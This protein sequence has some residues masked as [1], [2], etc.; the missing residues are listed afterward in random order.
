[1]SRK[2]TGEAGHAGTAMP[3]VDIVSVCLN[4]LAGLQATFESVRSQ[5]LPPQRWI[6][7][8]GGSTDGTQRWLESL[9]WPSLTWT[10]RADGGIYHGMNSGLV[11]AKS[12]YVLFLNS[13]DALADASVL[14]RIAGSLR[15][16]DVLPSLVF[17]DCFVVDEQDRH[18]L[19]RARAAWWTP[20]GMPTS[21][22]AMLFRRSALPRGFD[23]RF[24]LS[25]D[26]AAVARLYAAARGSDFL[27]L[28][29]PLCRFRLGG[30]SEQQRWLGLEEDLVI[31]REILRM[32][33]LGAATVRLAHRLQGMLK[34][35]LPAVHR[36]MRY[37]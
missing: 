10:S 14:S 30:R 34:S 2:S 24:R 5:V 35:H 4:D 12:D 20:L 37:Q 33:P 32:S 18:H 6:V 13:G 21:H 36:L 23:T 26:Y 22:Q 25:S 9:H 15:E 28:P 27:Y 11:A 19:R 3:T 1:M 29:V 8:D 17:G 7:A 16:A 31:R